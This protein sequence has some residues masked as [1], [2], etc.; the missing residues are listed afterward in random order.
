MALADDIAR[1]LEDPER[2]ARGIQWAWWISMA[3]VLF[4]YG[5]MAWVLFF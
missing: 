5:Y 4:G 3:V 1:F 2:R